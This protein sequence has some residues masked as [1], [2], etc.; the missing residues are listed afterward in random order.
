MITTGGR[1]FLRNKINTGIGWQIGSGGD[2]TNPNA[3]TLDSPITSSIQSSGI[4]ISSSGES[5]VDYKID[6][7][8]SAYVGRTIKEIGI[9]ETTGNTLICRVPLAAIGPLVSTD[10]IEVIITLEVD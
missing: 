8:G 7:S 3:T 4:T 2:S 9:Y 1:Q 5:T 10:E 6:I